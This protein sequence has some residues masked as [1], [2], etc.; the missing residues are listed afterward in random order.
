MKK[1][2]IGFAV[3]IFISILSPEVKTAPEIQL[4]YRQARGTS[5]LIETSWC[6][7]AKVDW[8]IVVVLTWTVMWVESVRYGR[9][10][11]RAVLQSALKSS[12][13]NMG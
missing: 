12:R 10:M 7:C 8:R 3:E 11:P 4:T 5:S 1:G 6:M 9:T 13:L 2:A